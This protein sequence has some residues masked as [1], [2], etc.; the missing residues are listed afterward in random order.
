MSL[1][2]SIETTDR[3]EILDISDM[4]SDAI[5]AGTDSGLCSVFVSHTTAGLVVN[6]AEDGL[7]RDMESTL[8]TL[9]RSDQSYEHDRI[10][11]NADAHLRSMLLNSN[12]TLPLEGGELGLGT[13]QSILF[14]EADGPRKRTV[15]ITIVD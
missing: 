12:V 6:E 3:L 4:V 5:P 7:L 14:V 11:N 1:K 2:R 10:D 8:K 9:I 13:W 15:Q